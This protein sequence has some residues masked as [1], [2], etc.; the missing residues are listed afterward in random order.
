MKRLVYIL[1]F[2]LIAFSA[3]SQSKF[4]KKGDK[5]YKENLYATA[6]EYYEKTLAEARSEGDNML[7]SYASF[8]IAECY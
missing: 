2:C 1:F 8:K 4:Q 7:A 6:R 5:A 3:I